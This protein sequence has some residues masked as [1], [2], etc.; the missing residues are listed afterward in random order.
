M[1]SHHTVPASVLLLSL[2]LGACAEGASP[3][4][5]FGGD[6]AEG[7]TGTGG[8]TGEGS[9]DGDFDLPCE[10]PPEQPPSCT[11][12]RETVYPDAELP[13]ALLLLDKSGS[14]DEAWDH[15]GD[16][17]TP[18]RTRWSSLHRTVRSLVDVVGEDLQVGAVLFPMDGVETT[19]TS[20]CMVQ[21][22]PELPLGS[23]DTASVLEALPDEGARVAGGTPTRAAVDLAA[24]H[25]GLLPEDRPAAVVLVTD[26]AANC[27]TGTEGPDRFDVYDQ[28]VE[29]AVAE[30][31]GSRGVPTYVVGIGVVDALGRDP[32][33]NA[34]EALT[35]VALAGG[36]PST[37][38][39]AYFAADD[40]AQLHAA[41]G[42]ILDAVSCT[43]SLGAPVDDPEL[44][45]VRSQGSEIP[46]VA[47]C[48]G[49]A[50]HVTPKPGDTTL[51]LCGAACQAPS[52]EVERGCP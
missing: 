39:T 17:A 16:P 50:A 13:A 44:L 34:H 1:P 24:A 29:G 28:S 5:G 42:Q 10:A 33:V 7:S 20:G 2:T 46:G 31:Y 25:L 14:M 43:V 18:E 4:R 26:G 19:Y 35:A 27:Q 38:A 32:A 48:A 21:D 40:E 11:T 45:A 51:R 52:L 12:E 6:L 47:A 22:W 8:D 3:G 36:V 49:A 9:G 30:L 37:G 41:L 15:D 23:Y